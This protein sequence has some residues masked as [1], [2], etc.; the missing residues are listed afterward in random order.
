VTG[1]GESALD[2]TRAILKACAAR[3]AASLEPWLSP[4]VSW[5][6]YGQPVT[7]GGAA[8][9]GKGATAGER[10]AEAII[11][12][13]E[14]RDSRLELKDLARLRPGLVVA[15]LDGTEALPGG[16]VHGGSR[17][18]AYELDAGTLVRSDVFAFRKDVLRHYGLSIGD[19]FGQLIVRSDD[20]ARLFHLPGPAAHYAWRSYAAR[21]GWEHDHCGIC[22]QTFSADSLAGHATEGYA[23]TGDPADEWLCPECLDEIRGHFGIELTGGPLDMSR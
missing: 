5:L 7:G 2:T 16:S 9:D 8:A 23:S 13:L 21:P 20:D 11:A 22:W 19:A 15:V 12:D 1:V 18:R 17:L 6:H 14:R 3:D 10:A 4:S